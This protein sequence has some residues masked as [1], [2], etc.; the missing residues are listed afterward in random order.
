MLNAY[1]QNLAVKRTPMFRARE[2][3]TGRVCSLRAMHHPPPS[4]PSAPRR[5]INA[6][7]KEHEGRKEGR[8]EGR[9]DAERKRPRDPFTSYES[10]ELHII[11]RLSRRSNKHY[12]TLARS[13]KATRVNGE[14]LFDIGFLSRFPLVGTM[15]GE[16]RRVCR[17]PNR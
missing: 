3:R 8:G 12:S 13:Y 7:T 4:L 6:T 14:F 5:E 9:G 11:I 2:Q 16:A 17:K 10:Y 15:W 1:K